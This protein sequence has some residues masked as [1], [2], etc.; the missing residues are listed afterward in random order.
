VSMVRFLL[1]FLLCILLSG[2]AHLPWRRAPEEDPRT[3]GEEGIDP[4]GFPQDQVIVTQQEPGGKLENAQD[5][6]VDERLQLTQPQGMDSLVLRKVYRVQ[7]FATKYPDEA[8]QVA[9]TLGNMVSESTY[10]DYKTPY[11]WVRVGDCETREEGERL[12]RRIKQLGYKESWVVEVE[13]EPE[14]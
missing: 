2:C 10:I 6:R 9:E 7:F 12:L 11:Y 14:D 5:A 1:C 4:L 3:R 13:V 8:S